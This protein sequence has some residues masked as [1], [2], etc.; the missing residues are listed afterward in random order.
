[1]I[2]TDNPRSVQVRATVINNPKGA[3]FGTAYTGFKN[4]AKA[5]G[6]YKDIKPY[7]PETYIDRYRYKPRKRISGYL[8]KAIH[9]K[10]PSRNQYH[11]KYGRRYRVNRDECWKRIDSK[12]GQC[13]GKYR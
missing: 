4:L 2:V 9:K 13:S 11:K 5:Y 10:I 3:V 1:M 8:G 6:F 12:S 7:F